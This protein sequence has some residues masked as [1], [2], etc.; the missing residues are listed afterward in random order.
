M[1]FEYR[2]YYCQDPPGYYPYVRDCPQG[3]DDGRPRFATA[4][5]AGALTSAAVGAGTQ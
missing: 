3:L 4:A 5:P 1:P 2:W